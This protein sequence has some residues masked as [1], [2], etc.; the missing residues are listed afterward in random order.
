MSWRRVLAAAVALLA[1]VACSSTTTDQHQLLPPTGSAGAAG[2]MP[3]GTVAVAITAP[4]DAA[5]V[6]VNSDLIVTATVDL[7]NG[8]DVIDTSTVKVVLTRMGSSAALGNGLL[9]SNGGDVYSGKLSLGNLPAG[10]YLVTVSGTSSGGVTASAQVSI[11]IDAGPVIT[12]MSPLANHG[13]NGSMAIQLTADGGAYPLVSGPTATIGGQTVTLTQDPGT[14]TYRALVAF[15]PTTPPPAGVQSLPPLFGQQLLDVKATNANNV[16]ADTRVAFDIDTSGPLISMTN[17][18]SGAVVGG[19]VRV[20]AAITD[21]SGVLDSSVVA[22]IGNAETPIF[23]LPMTAEGSGIYDVLFDTASLTRCPDPPTGEL[24]VVFPTISFRAVDLVGNQSVLTYGF[25]VDNIAPVADLDPPLLRAMRLTT[26]GYECSFKF[27]PLSINKDLG[28]MPNDGCLVPQVFDLRARIEDD[29]NQASEVKVIPLAGVDP[30]N[31]S[32]FILP[33]SAAQPLVVDSDGDG[34]CDEVNPL[35]L[36]ASPTSPPAVAT[37]L[38]QVRLAP[39]PLGGSADFRQ[40]KTVTADGPNV[41]CGPGTATA[42]PALLC[43]FEQPTIAISYAGGESSIWTVEPIDKAFHCLG[44]QLDTK[45]NGIPE[46]WACIAVQTRDLAGNQG[47]SVPMRV[48][49]QYAA[50]PIQ[51]FC[52]APPAS[53]GPPPTCTGTYDKASKT[54]GFGACSARKFTGLEYYCAPGQC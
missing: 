24:C 7:Q 23:E 30:Q 33:A 46:G 21:D 31:T 12:V 42:P 19:V 26:S 51:G 13:Y 14:T 28:D 53:A 20:S 34:R 27:D 39:V 47:T 37:P 25:S 32:V 48:Y 38:L 36:P 11:T 18:A 49:I 3:S 45:A 10:V 41:P 5:I 50:D 9:L 54:A 17:P 6:A 44:N 29:G 22:V 52:P 16:N 8:T 1:P 43:T 2:H 15:G 4:A 35:L 40:D